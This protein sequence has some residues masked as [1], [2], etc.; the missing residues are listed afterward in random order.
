[1]LMFLFPR[2][3]KKTLTYK[4]LAKTTTKTIVNGLHAGR[5]THLKVRN[6]HNHNGK[7]HAERISERIRNISFTCKLLRQAFPLD[8][9]QFDL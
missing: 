9:L 5:F 6:R 1:M 4:K 3:T 8:T 7:T 2:R